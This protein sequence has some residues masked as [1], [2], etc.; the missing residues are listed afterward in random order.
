MNPTASRCQS[1]SPDNAG[2]VPWVPKTSS[3]CLDLG[4]SVRRDP[5]MVRDLWVSGPS[6]TA[7]HQA[8]LMDY[9]VQ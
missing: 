8:I 9:A 5:R 4:I 6:S 2:L 1:G 3:S 7:R